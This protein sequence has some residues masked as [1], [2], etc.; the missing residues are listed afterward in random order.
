MTRGTQI[1][2]RHVG[3]TMGIVSLSCAERARDGCV[4]IGG[5]FGI[6]LGRTGVASSGATAGAEKPEEGRG[7]RERSSHPR[8]GIHITTQRGADAVWFEDRVEASFHRAVDAGRK[9]GSHEG[10]NCSHLCLH[11]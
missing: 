8:H 9:C 11:R 5:L 1:V 6:G 10:E 3:S 7:G 2:H 4:I